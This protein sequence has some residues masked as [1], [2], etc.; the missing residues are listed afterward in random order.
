MATT[1]I[2]RAIV[3]FSVLISAMVLQF[4]RHVRPERQEALISRTRAASYLKTNA[5]RRRAFIELLDSI[6]EIKTTSHVIGEL[7]GLQKLHDE[8]QREF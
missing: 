5:A 7:Q 3:D 2:R 8:E 4:S 1:I 6:S